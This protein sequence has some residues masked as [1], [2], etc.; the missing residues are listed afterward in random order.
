MMFCQRF[1]LYLYHYF[2]YILLTLAFFDIICYNKQ[3]RL[4]R[5]RDSLVVVPFRR[6]IG[7]SAHEH[8]GS[9]NTF[10]SRL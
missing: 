6:R 1:L 10:V 5:N 9:L 7:G 3:I 2:R 4:E 8:N